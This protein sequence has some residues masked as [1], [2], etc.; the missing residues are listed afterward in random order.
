MGA[1]ACCTVGFVGLLVA[2]QTGLASPS[3]TPEG[4]LALARLALLITVTAVAAVCGIAAGV[5]W[6]V[7]PLHD[8]R[9]AMSLIIAGQ[10]DA[11]LSLATPAR[12]FAHLEDAFQRMLAQLRDASHNSEASK[13]T[14]AARTT[15]VDRLLEFSQTI[16]GAGKPEQVFNTLCHFLS[17][18]LGLAGV[19]I[20]STDADAVPATQVRAVRPATLILPNCSAGDVILSLPTD[21]PAYCIP[22]MVRQTQCVVHMLLPIGRAWDDD[23]KDLAQTYVNTAHSALISL[24]LLAEA[25]R[26]SLTDGLTGLYNRRSMDQLMAREVALS[27]RHG[28]PLSV[29]M[30]DM[31]KFKEINDDHGHAAGD[32]LLKAFADCVRMTLRKT[33][34]AFRY[35]G[36]E[37]LIALPQTPVAQAQQVVQKLRQAF[38][39]IDFS[40]A[41]TNLKHH[42]TLS[43]GVAERSKGLNTLTLS[44]LLGAADAALYDAKT[45]NRN[46]VKLYTPPKAA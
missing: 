15:T 41:V 43:I 31:D 36:D 32:H 24:H 20:L 44:Q 17:Q 28:H 12:E 6:L 45:S 46:C 11:N 5:T 25:E 22:F 14:L 27:E 9:R 39:A 35:G 42:P 7:R 34:L 29:V 30:I 37:F 18:E 26:Q 3:S 33:D 40:D 2:W 16:Q 19:A 8:L 10:F 4:K 38:G 23:A 1:S 13:Q 21:H